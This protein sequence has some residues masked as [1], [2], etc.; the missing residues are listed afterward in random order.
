MPQGPLPVFDS[1]LSGNKS[2]LNI[3]AVGVIK[4]TPGRINRIVLTGTV[5]TGGALTI[6]DCATTAAAAA[7]NVVFSTAGT[8]AVGSV[9][10]LDWPCLVG[11]TVSAF[12]TGGAPKVAISFV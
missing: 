12:P 7:A 6:N 8:L 11:I 5:G 2:A 4:A 1:S 9:I 10:N 3:S